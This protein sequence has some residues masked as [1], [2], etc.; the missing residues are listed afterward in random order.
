MFKRRK[1]TDTAALVESLEKTQGKRS[2]YQ[3]DPNEWNITRDEAGNGGA[4]VRL[5]PPKGEGDE[6]TP[7]VRVMQHKFKHNGQWYIE[8]CPTNI[9][10]QC[11]VCDANRELWDSNIESNRKLA[12]ERKRKITY[13][14]NVVVL[15][16]SRNPD[17][18]GK[19]FKWHFGKQIMD[20]ILAK[21]KGDPDLGVAGVDVTDPWEGCDL[22]IRFEKTNHGGTY[23][24]STFET[25]TELFGGDEAKLKEVFESLH[26]LKPTVAP[27]TFKEF[28]QLEARYNK[29]TGSSQKTR[30]MDNALEEDINQLNQVDDTDDIPFDIDDKKQENVSSSDDID[31]LDD[32]FN[33]L[34]V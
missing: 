25:P 27:D 3:A 13:V 15:N 17:A 28:S 24:P 8:N 14:A 2:G 12:S 34:E 26:P 5:L 9:G 32:F 30:Q 1:N 20:K 11:P 4:R 16:D 7:F 31:D 10:Q 22:I 21:A 18:V 33:E 6:D 23:I 19:V 29:V